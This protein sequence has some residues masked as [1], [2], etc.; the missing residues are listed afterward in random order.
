MKIMV[1]RIWSHAGFV[2]RYEHFREIFCL[3]HQGRRNWRLPWSWRHIPP[4]RYQIFQTTLHHIPKDHILNAIL[5]IL[6]PVLLYVFTCLNFMFILM[7]TRDVILKLQFLR[8]T[9]SNN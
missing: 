2:E 6:F 5:H 7:L 4:E 8:R 9:K 1:S 3:H